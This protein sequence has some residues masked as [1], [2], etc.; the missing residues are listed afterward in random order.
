MVSLVGIL[1]TRIFKALD[2]QEVK[3]SNEFI[4]SL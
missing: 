2:M 3:E 1:L 4:I